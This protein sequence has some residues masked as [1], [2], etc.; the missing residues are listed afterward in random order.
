MR[1]VTQIKKKVTSMLRIK[2]YY[3]FKY[4]YVYLSISIFLYLIASGVFFT[5]YYNFSDGKR[6]V[7]CNA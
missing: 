7:S 2:R 4:L 6:R 1:Y 3:T 5:L